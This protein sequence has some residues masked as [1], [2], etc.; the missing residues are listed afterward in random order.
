[1][2]SESKDQELD[3][4]ETRFRE[5]YEKVCDAL[6]TYLVRMAG[7]PDL[8]ADA[9]QEAAYRA[10]RARRSFRGESAFRTWIYRIAIN[11]MKNMLSRTARDRKIMDPLDPAGGLDPAGSG[12]DPEALLAGRQEAARLSE[13][14][15]ILDEAYRAPFLL[16]H[17][18]G[19]SYREIGSVLGIGEGNA[20]MRVYRARQALL[21]LIKEV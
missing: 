20:R 16:K 3:M 10:Y 6:Y 21:E 18:D 7:D 12:R 13:A 4:D 11:T 15:A 1:M 14:L 19:M 17:V 9:L 5:E 8:A 2:N